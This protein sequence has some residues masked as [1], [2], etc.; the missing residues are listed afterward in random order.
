MSK[1]QAITDR[2]RLRSVFH[3]FGIDCYLCGD[4]IILD[5]VK[6]LPPFDHMVEVADDG[7][8]TPANLKPVHRSCHVHKSAKAET[9]R[10]RIDRLE[11]EKLGLPKRKRPKRAWTKGRKLQSRPMTTIPI[12]S[13]TGR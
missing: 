11:K 13:Q 4:R 3:H 10:S 9:Q 6:D 5:G 2:M 1:R 12:H 8:H 7:E